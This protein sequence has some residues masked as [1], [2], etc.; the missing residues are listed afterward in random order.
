[1]SDGKISGYVLRER[2]NHVKH[3]LGVTQHEVDHVLREAG[4]SISEIDAIAITSTQN[5]ELFTGLLDSFEID[6]SPHEA[7][8]FPSTLVRAFAA[9]GKRVEDLL[10]KAVEPAFRGVTTGFDS[11]VYKKVFPEGNNVNWDHFESVGWLDNYITDD[12]WRIPVG[13]SALGKR[14]VVLEDNL[15]F[16]FHLPV[17]VRWRGREIPS[18][19]VNHHMAHA[20]SCY[21]RSGFDRSAILTHDGFKSGNDY[22]GGLFAFGDG[23]RLWPVSPHFLAIGVLYELV[24]ASLNLGEVGGPGKLMGLASYGAPVM[25]DERFVCNEPSA[26]ESFGTDLASAWLTHCAVCVKQ[27]DYDMGGYGDTDS[28]TA[29]VN[30]D[31]A[32]STQ[33]LFEEIYLAAVEALSGMLNNASISC[34]NLCLSGGT[35]LNCPSNTRIA[36]ES[37]FKN[38]YVEPCC[39]DGGLSVGASLH[40]YHNL[41]GAPV[42]APEPYSTPYLGGIFSR[43]DIAAAIQSVKSEINVSEPDDPTL[44]AATDIFE[45]RII[46]WFEGRSETGPRALGHRSILANATKSENWPRV[47]RLK[48]REAWRPFA[49][50]VLEQDASDWFEGC[51][52]PSPYMLFNARVKGSD[53]PAVTH[54][55]GTAR[56][57]TVD[58]SCGRIFD[59]LTAYSRLSGIPV[60][61]NTSFNGPGEPIV[62]TPEEALRFLLQ[63]EIDAIYIEGLRVARR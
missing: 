41:M 4:I 56:I 15:R 12:N 20:A 59:V 58:P 54:V 2:H 27:G 23:N 51:P 25:F 40:V 33:K 13:L 47:N 17:V 31:I 11:I 44:A 55:D 21:Y 32:S 57:Q 16:G 35:A 42:Q 30:A 53:L 18:Y 46:G 3:A 60:V 34:D 22:H 24:A 8:G 26:Q 36:A 43:S 61:L 28:M 49:P 38:V 19:F 39:D 48:A 45:D 63:T 5:V 1:M 62:E 52:I 50:A 6:F 14:V 29:P 37:R 9:S 10:V 7:H